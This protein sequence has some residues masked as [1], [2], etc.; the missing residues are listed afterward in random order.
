MQPFRADWTGWTLMELLSI[1]WNGRRTERDVLAASYGWQAP[2]I[3][4]KVES[5]ER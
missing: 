1:R 2:G 4:V 3:P 5:F